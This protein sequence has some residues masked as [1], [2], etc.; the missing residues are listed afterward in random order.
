MVLET[1]IAILGAGPGGYVAALRAAQ[2]GAKVTLVEA[3]AIGGVCL[4]VGCI[5]TKALLRSA[6]VYRTLLRAEAFGLQVEGRVKPDWSAIQARK[7]LIVQQLVQG[8]EKL[9]HA[10]RVQVIRGQGRFVGPRTL[11]VATADGPQ[12]VEANS[13]LVA[14]GSRPVRLPLPGMDHPGV[15]DSTT[16]L[17]LETLPER[18]LVVGAGVVGLELAD[19]F[20]A[21]G[22]GVTLVEMLDRLLPQMDADLGPALA[23]TLE[24]RGVRVHVNSQVRQVDGVPG[25]LR[26]TIAAPDGEVTM[27]ADRILV[28][29]GRRPNVEGLGLE[30]AD[31]R[32]DKT[33]IQVNSR[34]Q[35]N[36]PDIY[37]VGDVT[38]GALLAH[39]AMRGGEVAVENALGHA[40]TF[41][42]KTVP[43]CVY[44][45]PG[46]A[47]VGLAEGQAREAG[48]D[49][50]VGRFPLT[51]S[52]KALTYGHTDGFVKVVG[53]ARFGEVLG[54]HIIAPHASDLI[55]EGGL[56]LALEATLDELVTTVHAHPTLAEA[57][58]EAAL[59]VRGGV[60]H[61]PRR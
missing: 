3:E 51:A 39:V 44:T 56:A 33:G 52:G 38:G 1:D 8:V 7:E 21:F 27:D 60:L 24:Q 9:L 50:Q 13:V 58:R 34:M 37:A 49:V 16:A 28:A 29:V 61:L 40:V 10:A 20:N 25:G 18:L 45:D 54:L 42:S 2:L 32:F 31:V 5:P 19:I 23:W 53:E 57:V 43:W 36:V 12:Q 17:A 11:E 41:D 6:E 4:N 26:A 48:Y 30:A 46:V 15:L 22:V 55:H 14:T 59:D 35:T 47:S